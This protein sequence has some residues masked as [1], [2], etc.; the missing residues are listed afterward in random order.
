[1]KPGGAQRLVGASPVATGRR[2]QRRKRRE[3]ER[4]TLPA[5]GDWRARRTYALHSLGAADK[6]G[7]AERARG[8]DRANLA[9]PAR[10]A[11]KPRGSAMNMASSRAVGAPGAV[12][13]GVPTAMRGPL[14]RTDVDATVRSIFE[15]P[16]HRLETSSSTKNFPG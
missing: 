9:E 15:R 7:A 14:A 2:Q 8:K 13:V 11:Q 1:V 6:H 10:A 4:L 12:I 5:A 16:E 3:L